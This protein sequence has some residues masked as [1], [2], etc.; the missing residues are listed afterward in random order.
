MYDFYILTNNFDVSLRKLRDYIDKRGTI[1]WDR[2]PFRED[3]LTEYG[4][5]YDKLRVQTQNGILITKPEFEKIIIRLRDFMNHF[6][7]DVKWNHL[8][9]QFE[10]E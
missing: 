4:K 1:E 10:Q 6:N 3:V 9:R 2:D 7:E 8:E 5:A